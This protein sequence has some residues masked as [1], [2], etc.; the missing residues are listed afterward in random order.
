MDTILSAHQSLEKKGN[1]SKTIT[2]VQTLIDQLQQTRDAVAANP[3]LTPL[4]MAKLKQP[5]KAS[6]DKIEDDLKE[7]NK[8]LNH[9]QKALKDKFKNSQL[10]A[11]GNDV[12][13]SQE[14]LVNRSIAMHLLR[15]GKFGV[16]RTFVREVNEKAEQQEEGNLSILEQDVDE[17]RRIAAYDSWMNDF[18]DPD[19]MAMD[20]DAPEFQLGITR[21]DGEVLEGKGNLQRKFAEMYLILDALRNQHN[22]E[23]AIA[24]AREHSTE[25]EA[26]GS[27]LEFE[28]CRLKFVELYTSSSSADAMSDIDDFSGPLRALQYAQTVFPTFSSRYSRDISNLVGSL[29]FSPS[30]DC[31]PYYNLFFNTST[32]TTISQSFTREFCTLLGLSSTSPLYTAL[33]AGSIA[34]P[35]LQKYSRI[36]TTTK[37]QWTSA[38]ELPVE[39]PLPP[40]MSY[41]S[42]FVCPVSKEQATDTNFPVMLPCGHVI[43]RESLEMH[44]RGKTRVK[45]PYCPVECAAREARRVYI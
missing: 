6:F 30:L 11:A 19:A 7:V 35:V 12:L 8:G 28:L 25:L 43:A 20:L 45:C 10:P 42:I 36:I 31:S 16:A 2:D 32:W 18:S 34:L 44:A 38:N 26:R 21:E 41:H 5:V 17:A 39:T 29:A 15:E 14:W 37:G 27:N 3:E 1:L 4:H 13:E 22:L 40:A 33:T 23:P 24:W 9:Y